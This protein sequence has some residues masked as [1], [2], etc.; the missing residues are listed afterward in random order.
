MCVFFACESVRMCA[1]VFV[2]V[3]VR[4]CVCVY[5]CACVRACVCVCACISECV[6]VLSSAVYKNK[7]KRG[8]K[9]CCSFVIEHCSMNTKEAEG[10]KSSWERRDTIPVYVFFWCDGLFEANAG[11]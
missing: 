2:C 8:T 7:G 1:C 3:C 10:E 4:A 5:V 11:R 9:V 6:C